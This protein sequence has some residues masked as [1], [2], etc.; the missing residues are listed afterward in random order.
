MVIFLKKLCYRFFT[1]MNKNIHENG[2]F[3]SIFCDLN[4]FSSEI[5]SRKATNASIATI[6][7]KINIFKKVQDIFVV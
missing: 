4:L 3:Q 5:P 2:F 7:S 6:I 1:L